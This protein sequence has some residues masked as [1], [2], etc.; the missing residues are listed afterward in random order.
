MGWGGSGVS[1]GSGVRVGLVGV[2]VKG[3]G[4]IASRYLPLR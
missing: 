2:V 3:G 1:L 4:C